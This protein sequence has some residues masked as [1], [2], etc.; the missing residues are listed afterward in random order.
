MFLWPV[1]PPAA[2]PGIAAASSLHARQ[3]LQ[4]GTALQAF[5]VLCNL[6]ILGEY[7]PNGL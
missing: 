2:S 1:L 3:S 4:S 5:F 7:K 6:G